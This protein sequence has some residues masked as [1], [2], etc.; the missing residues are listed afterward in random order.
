MARGEAR[1][2]FRCRPPGG[3]AVCRAV[4]GYRQGDAQR[5]RGGFSAGSAPAAAGGNKMDRAGRTPLANGRAFCGSAYLLS[6]RHVHGPA[7]PGDLSSSR[8]DRPGRGVTQVPGFADVERPIPVQAT[9]NLYTMAP[10]PSPMPA[11]CAIACGVGSRVWRWLAD[12]QLD[13]RRTQPPGPQ[14]AGPGAPAGASFAL[15]HPS[16]GS[17][18]GMSR[19][20]PA[21]LL[22]ARQQLA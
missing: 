15:C 19:Y 5:L 22:A 20:Q 1:W 6:E 16:G 3:D 21:E 18:S 11:R 12:G 10:G 4:I 2:G 17:A 13:K 7:M 9:P 8:P 14:P